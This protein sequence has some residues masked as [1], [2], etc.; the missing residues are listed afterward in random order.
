MFNH[1][2][3]DR[4]EKGGRVGRRRKEGRKGKERYLYIYIIYITHMYN[5]HIY[6]IY[7]SSIYHTSST[8]LKSRLAFAAYFFKMLNDN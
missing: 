1:N 6:M 5:I 2:S 4:K 7:T 8:F 3:Q